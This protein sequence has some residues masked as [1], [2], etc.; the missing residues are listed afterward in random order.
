MVTIRLATEADA[1]AVRAIYAPIVRDTVISFEFVPPDVDEMRR[2]IAHT[3]ARYPWLVY[4]RADE[5]L[6]YAYA[7]P[8]SERAAY[9][10]SVNV[11]VYVSTVARRRG[12]GRAL[13][14]SLFAL[15]RLQ[16][17]VN[18]YAGVSLPN[19]ASVG[20]H[21]AM[22]MTPVGVYRRV[23]YKFGAWHDV[24]WWQM[25]L[26]QHPAEPRPP[27]ALAEAQALPGWDEA[28]A[29]GLADW[30]SDHLQSGVHL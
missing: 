8:H 24:G 6:G 5:V 25:A 2:R 28:M 9:Q 16:G 18:V 4:A 26:C 11:S 3:L 23:G 13:Y 21:E 29:R 20:L 27:L 1:A 17:F 19:D 7:G 14:R 10:W 22:G 30:R 12:V 15:L